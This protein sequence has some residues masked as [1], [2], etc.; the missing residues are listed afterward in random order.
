M[1][2]EEAC[3]EAIFEMDRE[4]GSWLTDDAP[5]QSWLRALQAAYGTDHPG[6]P[7]DA[8]IAAD[9]DS[10]HPHVRPEHSRDNT[11]DMLD[12]LASA[13]HNG[14]RWHDQ[15]DGHVAD[16]YEDCDQWPCASMATLLGAPCCWV[17]EREETPDE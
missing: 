14:W 3:R 4:I 6:V 2:T 5:G 13:Y 16:R 10:P 15:Q 7:S 1:T 17:E 11:R 9:S 12:M 8:V